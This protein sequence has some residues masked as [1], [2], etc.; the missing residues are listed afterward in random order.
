[1]AYFELSDET[2]RLRSA[3]PRGGRYSLPSCSVL[4]QT[5]SVRQEIDCKMQS[6]SSWAK[7]KLDLPSCSL[8]SG[9]S[10]YEARNRLQ[11]AI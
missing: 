8:F 11:V 6:N 1:M 10:L 2:G 5:A 7:P 4:T 9:C 3:A